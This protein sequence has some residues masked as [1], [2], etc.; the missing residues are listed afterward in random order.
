MVDQAHSRDG[1]SFVKKKKA[2]KA[3]QRPSGLKS[4]DTIELEIAADDSEPYRPA[5]SSKCCARCPGD[6]KSTSFQQCL[7]VICAVRGK[8]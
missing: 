1:P 6:E 4:R 7:F 2:A 8:I 5:P 3:V